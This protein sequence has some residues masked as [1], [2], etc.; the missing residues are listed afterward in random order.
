[1]K[2]QVYNSRRETFKSK[3]VHPTQEIPVFNDTGK[4]E[5]LGEQANQG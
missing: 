5:I 3:L 4:F 2:V 1:M